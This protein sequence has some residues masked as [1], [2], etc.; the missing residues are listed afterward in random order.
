MPPEQQTDQHE[1][2]IDIPYDRIDPDALR[3]MIR[4]FVSREWAD[5]SDS[6]FTLEEKICQVLQQ[7][8]EN[9][10]TVVYDLATET[11]NIVVRR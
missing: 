3:N 1:R 8:K 7:L 10:A 2:G 4:E 9:R 6:G 5:L 11:W